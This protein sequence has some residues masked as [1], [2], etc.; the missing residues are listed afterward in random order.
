MSDDLRIETPVDDAALRDWQHVHNAIIPTAPLSLDEVRERVRRNHLE[1]VYL[2]D[3]LLGCS[4]LRPPL[5]DDATRTA[6]VIVRVLPAYRGRGHGAALCARGIAQ[7]R[8]LG[9]RT[10]ETVVLASNPEGLRFAQAHG[11][12]E[13]ERYVLPGDTVPFVTLRLRE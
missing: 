3:A 1:V 8:G 5:P 11:F 2:A 12:E 13:F 4:T 7:A 9:A 10:V 6:T